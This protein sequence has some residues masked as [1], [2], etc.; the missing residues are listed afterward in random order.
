ME[1]VSGIGSN[2]GRRQCCG[3]N[4]NIKTTYFLR[5]LIFKDNDCNDRISSKL[6]LNIKENED[7]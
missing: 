7:D 3:N 5:N 6:N 1:C 2:N 4:R